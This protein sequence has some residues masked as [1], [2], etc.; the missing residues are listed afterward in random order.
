MIGTEEPQEEKRRV[1]PSEEK[2]EGE[3][4]GDIT[5]PLR[6]GL[7]KVCGMPVVGEAPFCKDHEFPV[8]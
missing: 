1:A 8:P 3:A 7:C 5:D 4:C 2:H 6:R